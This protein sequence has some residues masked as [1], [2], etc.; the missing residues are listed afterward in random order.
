MHYNPFFIFCKMAKNQKQKMI[1]GIDEVGRGCL[2]GPVLVCAITEL[3]IQS[4]RHSEGVER[5][6]NLN[7]RDSKKTS[8]KKRE[9]IYEM[10][11]KH[12]QV[13]WGIGRVSE[14]IIDKINIFQATKLAMEKAVLALEKKI[15]QPA[16]M[17]L[18]DG[19]FGIGLNRP[20]QS[21]I[22][23]DEKIFLI[24][25]ASIVAKVERDRLMIKM[26]RKYP[27]YGFD[28]HKGYG[29]KLHCERLSKFGCCPLHRRSFAPIKFFSQKS[30]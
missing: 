2:A 7:G 21:I 28:Q 16:N 13:E 10:L 15:G 11:K 1:V 29:T 4:R 12:P 23:G 22:K 8:P 30:S 6:K 26:H 17:L 18:I 24:S 19:N 3:K 5:P 20:Q 25:L 14:K 27:Q 9:E